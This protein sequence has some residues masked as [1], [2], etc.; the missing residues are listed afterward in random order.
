MK[1]ILKELVAV[2][3]A[4]LVAAA[5]IFAFT[6]Y[7]SVSKTDYETFVGN[8]NKVPIDISSPAYGEVLTLPFT[9]G[10]VVRQGQTLATIQILVPHF[11]PPNTSELFYMNGNVLSIQSPSDGIVGKIA[12]APQSTIGGTA[13]L[14]QIYT[15]GNTEIQILLPQGK[16]MSS[17]KA[18]YASTT[19]DG[20]RFPLQVLSQVPTDI[21]SNIAPTTTVY[22]A[23]CQ[24]VADCQKIVDSES[25]II[26]AQKK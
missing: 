21:V 19:P 4:L 7:V 1:K 6:Q 9:E 17:Y 5:L 10:A 8:V 22:R 23:K 25:I 24:R 12:L 20:P 2:V 11:T 18:F 13:T 14:M 16:A 3:G 26:Y 15:V